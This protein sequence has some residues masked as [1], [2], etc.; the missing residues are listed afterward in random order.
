MSRAG[1][2]VYNWK[3]FGV[4]A[5]KWGYNN[6]DDIMR[7]TRELLAKKPSAKKAA[8]SQVLKGT[9]LLSYLDNKYE[10]KCGTEV[11]QFYS[12]TSTGTPTTTLATLASPF[13]GIAQGLTDSTRIGDTIE[14]KKLRVRFTIRAG[15]ASTANSQVRI[16]VTKQGLMAGAAPTSDDI[17][18]T[19]NDIRSFYAQNKNE[20]F[21]ILSDRTFIV[22]PLTTNDAQTRFV[23]DYVYK[24]KGCHSIKWVSGDTTGVIGN[25]I[26]G[27]ICIKTMY[28]GGTAP[29][30]DFYVH[31]EYVDV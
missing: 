7:Y 16:I 13:V 10:K 14:V 3:Q 5:A 24:P 26:L 21:Q 8:P 25:M 23:Y 20:T 1:P 17:L 11:K 15:A 6:K 9:R 27:N 4:A 22:T 19:T 31:G 30:L 2:G 12:V 18:Q 29:Q 28:E